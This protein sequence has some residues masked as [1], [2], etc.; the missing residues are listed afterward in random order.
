LAEPPHLNR[1]P[2]REALVDIRVEPHDDFD[3]ASLRAV[4]I[5]GFP[6][7]DEQTVAKL[8]FRFQRDAPPQSIPDL[9]QLNGIFFRTKDKLTLV[10]FRADGFTYNRLRPYTSWEQI[11][12]SAYTLWKQYEKVAQPKAVLRLALRYIN[13]FDKESGFDFRDVLTFEPPL[14]ESLSSVVDVERYSARVSVKTRDGDL[15][16]H[17]SQGV[18]KKPGGD[19]SSLL[20]DIDA[21]HKMDGRESGE[22]L[23]AKIT[24]V[25]GRLHKFKN[26]IFFSCLAE[27]QVKEFE[28]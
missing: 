12:P 10:Q 14:P 19:T 20:L 6:N 11:W 7:R 18:D 16:A 17:I 1:A 15:R 5:E 23:D 22:H 26:D 9:P 8:S 21:F 4:E 3:A 27:K 13:E 25:F 28:L 24:G 2:L